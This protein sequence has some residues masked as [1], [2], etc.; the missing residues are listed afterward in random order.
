MRFLA[1]SE[2]VYKVHRYIYTSEQHAKEE[3]EEVTEELTHI[4]EW[5]TLLMKLVLKTPEALGVIYNK[6]MSKKDQ[7]NNKVIEHV[8]GLKMLKSD[9]MLK[10]SKDQLLILTYIK[11]IVEDTIKDRDNFED[12]YKKSCKNLIDHKV[13]LNFASKF[14]V[15]YIDI[16]NAYYTD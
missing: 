3:K 10:I 14:L 7:N 1:E 6:F 2:I 9:E 13:F 4:S 15:N 5:Y 11:N 12:Q 16:F 8:S